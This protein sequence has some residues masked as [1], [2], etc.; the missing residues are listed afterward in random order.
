MSSY[1]RFWFAIM[2]GTTL[3]LLFCVTPLRQRIN[4]RKRVFKRHPIRLPEILP[5]PQTMAGTSLSPHISGR[6]DHSHGTSVRGHDISVHASAK[7][8]F[9][10]FNIGLM[11]TIEV[12]KQHF[13]FSTDGIWIKLSDDKALPIND[14]D[15]QSIKAKMT[16][17]LLTPKVGYRVV[18]SEKFKIDAL[19]GIRYWHQKTGLSFEPTLFGG[20]S[21]SKNWVDVVG[22]A[23][24]QMSLSPKVLVTI[25]GRCGWRR[26]DLDYQVA[27]LL[28]YRIG[29]KYVLGAGWRYLDIN[30][31][32]QGFSLRRGSER[33]AAGPD[34]QA[35][36]WILEHA[37]WFQRKHLAPPLG[38][39][40]ATL[41]AGKLGGLSRPLLWK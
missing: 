24:I 41:A 6:V 5:L 20:V 32:S 18:D 35:S 34:H 4:Q 2:L 12:R 31:R 15:V 33:L 13:V 39:P 1:L 8:L 9:T 14:R 7:D 30:Y 38:S 3:G 21:D 23:K 25:A 29:K 19:W 22:G 10:Y 26:F 11:G 37:Y 28:G 40:L 36:K 17:V 16:Q 27:G